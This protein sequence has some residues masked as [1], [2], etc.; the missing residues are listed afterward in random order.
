MEKS[1]GE[2]KIHFYFKDVTITLKDRAI[3]K[4]FIAYLFKKERKELKALNYIF[5]SDKAL[6]KINQDFLGHDFYTDIITFNFS[7]SDSPIQGEA[8][9]STDRVIEN[10]RIFQN[11]RKQ[12]LLRVILHGALHLCGYLDK[13]KKQRVIMRQK[14]ELYLKLWGKFHVKHIY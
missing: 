1:I 6:L 9:I 14:E 12:E 2:N 13:T 4:K 7:N 10:S 5:C 8:Y 3:L 11:T